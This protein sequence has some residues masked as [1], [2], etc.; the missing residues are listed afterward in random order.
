MEEI[1]VDIVHAVVDDNVSYSDV[2]VC[3]KVFN[4]LEER[5]VDLLVIFGVFLMGISMRQLEDY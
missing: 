4:P 5:F 3:L 2:G 1:L